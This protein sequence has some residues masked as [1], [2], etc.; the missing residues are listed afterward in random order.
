M[1]RLEAAKLIITREPF[2]LNEISNE[3][4]PK[5]SWSQ[6]RIAAPRSMLLLAVLKMKRLNFSR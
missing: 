2:D 5:Q 1:S 6:A 3:V 4:L